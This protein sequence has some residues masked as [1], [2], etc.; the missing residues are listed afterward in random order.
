MSLFV[1]F[2]SI[3]SLFLAISFQTSLKNLSQRDV[4][5]FLEG[6]YYLTFFAEQLT[7]TFE[8]LV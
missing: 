7:R 2:T 4:G 8:V 5:T 1:D 6:G 3:V